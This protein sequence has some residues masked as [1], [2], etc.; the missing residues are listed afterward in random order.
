MRRQ[1]RLVED[2]DVSV[3]VDM[4]WSSL[5]ARGGARTGEALE[6]IVAIAV[7]VVGGT[8]VVAA[9]HCRDLYRPG[10]LLRSAMVI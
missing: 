6:T 3:F 10:G 4:S 9:L 2:E 8:M 1:T 5:R 7:L